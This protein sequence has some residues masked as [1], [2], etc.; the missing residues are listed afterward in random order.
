[1]EISDFRDTPYVYVFYLFGDRSPDSDAIIEMARFPRMLGWMEHGYL[2]SVEIGDR[3]TRRDVLQTPATNPQAFR[4]QPPSL[5]FVTVYW[6]PDG[7][8]LSWEPVDGA[9]SYNVY[10]TTNGTD[11]MKGVTRK[12]EGAGY[13]MASHGGCWYF[14]KPVPSNADYRYVVTAVNAAG[15]SD[16]KEARDYFGFPWGDEMTGALDRE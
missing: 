1:M 9:A 15:E 3:E 14:H 13:E 4:V 10:W 11:P 6:H 8:W 16:R 7:R 5:R 2:A 12:I